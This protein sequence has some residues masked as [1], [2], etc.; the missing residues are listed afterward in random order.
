MPLTTDR[1]RCRASVMV[2]PLVLVLFAFTSGVAAD[3]S[4]DATD[5]TAATATM[6]TLPVDDDIAWCSFLLGHA[7]FASAEV[8]LRKSATRLDL[9]SGGSRLSM[10]VTSTK[11]SVTLP[12]TLTDCVWVD[13][14]NDQHYERNEPTSLVL[15]VNPT[16]QRDGD[17]DWKL[18]FEHDVAKA[19]SAAVCDRIVGVSVERDNDDDSIVASFDAN[20]GRRDPHD[21][22]LI[23]GRIDDAL[24]RLHS[25]ILRSNRACS[26]RLDT[27]VS[28][29]PVAALLSVAGVAMVGCA[30][31]VAR[32]RHRFV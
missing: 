13:L 10:Q 18:Q 1:R 19:G 9:P 26:P 2:C 17:G 32:R 28:E 30:A 4:T 11:D 6:S 29:A 7:P 14:N 21:R 20:S 15:L 8:N 31:L 3:D 5:P 16:W 22:R 25:H 12:S 24:R 27:P 23:A